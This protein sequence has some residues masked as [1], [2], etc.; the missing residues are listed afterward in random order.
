MTDPEAPRI[1]PVDELDISA[2]VAID[3]K[4]GGRYRPEVWE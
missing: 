1:R 4:I 3:E 2:V